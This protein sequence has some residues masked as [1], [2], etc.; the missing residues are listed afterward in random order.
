GAT[1]IA[2]GTTFLPGPTSIY[3][4]TTVIDGTSTIINPAAP[5]GTLPGG[6]NPLQRQSSGLTPAQLAGTL[7][8]S[9]LGFLLL[10]ALLLCC[11]L[12]RQRRKRR[13]EAL[14]QSHGIGPEKYQGAI[15]NDPSGAGYGAGGLRGSGEKSALLGLGAAAGA[16]AGAGAGAK[17]S[18][19]FS[20]WF[21]SRGNRLPS[22]SAAAGG[23]TYTALPQAN[24]GPNSR[25]AR[26]GSGGSALGAG[27]VGAS[28]A[29]V[30]AIAAI[31]SRRRRRREEREQAGVGPWASRKG[32]LGEDEW[33]ADE[34]DDDGGS[35]FFVV[36]GRNP[37]ERGES[38]A[39]TAGGRDEGDDITDPFADVPQDGPSS[40]DE[41]RAEGIAAAAGAAVIAA[42]RGRNMPNYNNR[43]GGGLMVNDPSSDARK[44]RYHDMANLGV[45]GGGGSGPRFFGAMMGTRSAS[46]TDSGTG[47]NSNSGPSQRNVSGG[48]H[49]T[50]GTQQPSVRSVSNPTYNAAQDSGVSTYSG[51]G[52]GAGSGMMYGLTAAAAGAAA[53][54]GLSNAAR[55]ISSGEKRLSRKPVPQYASSGTDTEAED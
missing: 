19:S 50:P 31:S 45:G 51:G 10:L 37:A 3:S 15:A 11:L 42:G 12:R 47:S 23:G 55:R 27:F 29:T 21:T 20:N 41:H 22:D 13:Q 33:E 2:S 9:I 8:G 40:T 46:G 5:S 4:G 34:L 39:Y 14:K 28:A 43:S 49:L 44:S 54:L 25:H 24:V 6:E 52:G 18:S 7:V 1:S 48:T 38:G 16:G 32:A 17:R 36:G 26:T 53:A 35:G 30:A